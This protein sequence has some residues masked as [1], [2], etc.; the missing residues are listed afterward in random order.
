LVLEENFLSALDDNFNSEKA[1]SYFHELKNLILREIS[2]AGEERLSQLKKLFEDFCET[3][4]GIAVGEEQSVNEYMRTLLE[5][6]KEARRN[7]NW[8]ESDRIRKVINGRGYEIV[9]NKD[10]TSVLVKKI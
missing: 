5:E 8:T 10:G 9:D 2:T 6:R 1:L 4:L 3:S 7:K